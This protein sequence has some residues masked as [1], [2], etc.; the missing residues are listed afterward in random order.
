MMKGSGG[1]RFIQG[2]VPRMF[3]VIKEMSNLKL[4]LASI[5]V[6]IYKFAQEI[7]IQTMMSGMTITL[8]THFMGFIKA[9]RQL[10]S[11]KFKNVTLTTI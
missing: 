1:G 7:F 8:K 6:N 11:K 10:N 4:L 2:I 5:Q 3:R 9:Q